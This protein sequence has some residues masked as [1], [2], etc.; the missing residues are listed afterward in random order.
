M[1]AELDFVRLTMP[2]KVP[3]RERMVSKPT[4]SKDA[5]MPSSLSKAVSGR[6]FTESEHTLIHQG[7]VKTY[8]MVKLCVITLSLALFNYLL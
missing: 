5:V 1:Y 4:I 3:C 7:P 8:F 6:P 2:F